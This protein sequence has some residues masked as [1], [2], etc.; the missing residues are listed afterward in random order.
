[1]SV[2]KPAIPSVPNDP[3]RHHFDRALKESLETITGART[4]KIAQ[5]STNASLSDVIAKINEILVAMQ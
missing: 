1:M 4:Y 3:D 5:L 2:K